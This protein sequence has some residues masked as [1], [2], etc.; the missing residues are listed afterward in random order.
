M[1]DAK[2]R[3]GFHRSTLCPPRRLPNAHGHP[4]YQPPYA[5]TTTPV[6]CFRNCLNCRTQPLVAKR[7]GK[8]KARAGAEEEPGALT[9]LVEQVFERSDHCAVA[10]QLLLA[11]QRVRLRPRV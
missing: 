11:F 9:S 8:D 5:H 10:H 7:R 1:E 6:R 2:E 4:P 3:E